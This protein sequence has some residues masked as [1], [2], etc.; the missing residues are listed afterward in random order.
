MSSRIKNNHRH[1][2]NAVMTY[3]N[4]GL[5]TEK[6]YTKKRLR[7]ELSVVEEEYKSGKS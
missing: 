6:G 2:L 5:L 3:T 7:I 1:D 4:A